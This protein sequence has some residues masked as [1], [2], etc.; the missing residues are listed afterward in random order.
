MADIYKTV[1]ELEEKARPIISST[2]SPTILNKE[3]LQDQLIDDLVFT[4]EFSEDDRVKQAAAQLIISLATITG[5]RSTSIYPLYHAFGEGKIDGFTVPSL[6]LRTLT[7]DLARVVFRLMI[8]HT[9]GAVVFELSRGEID[10]T[11]QRPQ[12]YLVALLAAA[13]KEGYNGP[14][15]VLGDHYQFSQQKFAEDREK[16]ISHLK[17]LIKESLAAGYG[18][19]DI[20]ASTLVDLKQPEHAAQ[21]KL[22]SEMTALLTNFIRDIQPQGQTISVGGEIGHIG[23]RNSTIEDFEAFMGEYLSQIH[24]I[25]ISKVSVQTGTSHGGTPLPDG[26]L[27]PVTVDF[28]VLREISSLARE[29]YHIGGAVQHGASTLPDQDFDH[30]VENK[31]LEVHLATGL[32]NIIYDNLPP[33]LREE[34]YH[35]IHENL[36]DERKAEWDDEQFIYKTRKRALG[37]FKEVLWSMT[38]EEKSVILTPLEDHLTIIFNKLKTFN[39]KASVQQFFQ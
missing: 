26:T 35:W 27:K 37:P 11:H 21:Q 14:V 6:N 34:I 30:F 24:G 12:E 15:F 36:A 38:P 16:E 28:S 17:E 10:Y 33:D 32:Q 13:I 4:A 25:G 5:A 22:N 1:S 18:N 2:N 9:I 39:T 3:A 7:Y 29:K 20:D 23:D 8:Q 19:I 31:T